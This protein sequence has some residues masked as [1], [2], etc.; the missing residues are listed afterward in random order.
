MTGTQIKSI[1]NATRNEVYIEEE[2]TIRNRYKRKD[3]TV[4]GKE[5]S[6]IDNHSSIREFEINSTH[7]KKWLILIIHFVQHL[8]IIIDTQ[9]KN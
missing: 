7:T 9:T 3:V 2:V 5:V 6:R 8:I 1:K 4:H